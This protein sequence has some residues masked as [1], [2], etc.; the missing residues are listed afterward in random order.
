[1]LGW[2]AHIE[3]CPWCRKPQAPT[4]LELFSIGRFDCELQGYRLQYP[5]R[6]AYV[7]AVV[8]HPGCGPDTG[9]ALTLDELAADPNH[10]FEHISRK[11]WAPDYLVDIV[12]DVLLLHRKAAYPLFHPRP[13]RGR[14]TRSRIAR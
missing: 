1:V 13:A 4:H 9:Y 11:T 10:W 12:Y 8:S 3:R 7:V 6:D 2:N 5:Q 14:L